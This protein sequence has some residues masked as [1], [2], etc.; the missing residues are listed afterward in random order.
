MNKTPKKLHAA[1]VQ[2]ATPVRMLGSDARIASN[3][4]PEPDTAGDLTEA[5]LLE[6]DREFARSKAA[7][8]FRQDEAD[9][10]MRRAPGHWR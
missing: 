9:R 2:R 4:E 3:D 5:D 8:P 7:D 6:I 10:A 1:D